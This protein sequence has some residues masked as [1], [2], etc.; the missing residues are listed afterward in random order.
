MAPRDRRESPTDASSIDALVAEGLA[1]YRRGDLDCARRAWQRAC[2]A[3]PSDPRAAEYLAHIENVVEAGEPLGERRHPPA[4]EDLDDALT[5][6]R[7]GVR[8]PELTLDDLAL[9]LAEPDSSDR[10]EAGDE[11]ATRER[12]FASG[13][14]CPPTPGR[15]SSEPTF[16]DDGIA[17]GEL[18]AE[19]WPGVSFDGSSAGGDDEVTTERAGVE[20][21]LG[22]DLS[23]SDWA[24]GARDDSFAEAAE[25]ASPLE[26]LR[27][28][29]LEEIGRDDRPGEPE[30]EALSRRLDALLAIV[31]RETARENV[32]GAAAA[33]DIAMLERPDSAL[34][35]KRLHEHAGTL[36][37]AFD[38]LLGD[39][40]RVPL[41]ALPMH[42]I[43]TQKLDSRAAFLL[44]RIDGMLSLEEIFDVSG[45]PRLEASSYLV[46]LVLQGILEVR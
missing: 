29:W 13:E 39:G 14:P 3:A 28:R 1:C 40:K 15:A 18:T 11:D 23:L 30:E 16:D 8:L 46:R 6:E 22:L 31:R 44:S 32:A 38:G 34:A 43:P 12:S 17:A 2:D 10:P 45:M 27:A 42:E 26:E 5:V 19:R 35:Q 24:E 41:V 21:N 25:R 20:I 9:E 37:K 7:P 33:A 4:E 36:L